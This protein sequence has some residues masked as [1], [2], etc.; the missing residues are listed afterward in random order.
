M[1][2]W[3]VRACNSH[4]C[5]VS[6]RSNKS[7]PSFSRFWPPCHLHYLHQQP[8]SWRAFRSRVSQLRLVRLDWRVS[9]MPVHR[10][11]PL[12]CALYYPAGRMSLAMS[13]NQ[14]CLECWIV[15][16]GSC[17]QQD[18]NGT[19]FFVEI[20]SDVV[21]N[22]SFFFSFLWFWLKIV[23]FVLGFDGGYDT[24]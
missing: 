13:W 15:N 10:A 18:R 12:Y 2:L 5:L 20:L 9:Y 3:F 4:F 7:M 21:T 16:T 24:I 6:S 22:D 1:A 23:C 19:F 8:R 17:K 11:N 14:V